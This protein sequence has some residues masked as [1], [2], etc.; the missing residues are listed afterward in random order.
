MLHAVQLCN[1]LCSS[2][3]RPVYVQCPK[4]I[5]NF[6]DPNYEMATK[7]LERLDMADT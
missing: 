1:V 5:V 6:G 4:Y 7:Y 2:L 3:T